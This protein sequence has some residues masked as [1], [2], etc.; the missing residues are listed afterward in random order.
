MEEQDPEWLALV[1]T[2]RA[3]RV[4]GDAV[5]QLA[6]RHSLDEARA[7][8]RLVWMAIAYEVNLVEAAGL[9]AEGVDDAPP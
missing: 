2:V 4:L 1:A 3:R 7:I 8:R 5:Q 6:T 9:V